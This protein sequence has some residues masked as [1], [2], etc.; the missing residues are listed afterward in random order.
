MAYFA[1]ARQEAAGDDAYVDLSEPVT[2]RAYHYG[3][4]RPARSSPTEG[5][6][7]QRG[8]AW[9]LTIPELKSEHAHPKATV[10]T[11]AAHDGDDG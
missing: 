9:D 2:H 3:Q 7:H 1:A 10:P 5:P 11:M 6:Y 4:A 8:P